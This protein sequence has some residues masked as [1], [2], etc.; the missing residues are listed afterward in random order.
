MRNDP[1]PRSPGGD[2]AAPR[3]ALC[4]IAARNYLPSVQL[5]VESFRRH[6]A[7]VAVHAL[8]VDADRH[9]ET[10]DLPFE[11]LV[12]EDLP[13]SGDEFGRM[14]T[15][16]DITELSTALKPTLMRALLDTFDVVMYLDPDIEVFAPLDG[17]FDSARV[18]GIA[19][20]PH[21]TR[22]LPRDGRD[23]ADEAFLISGQFN[24]GFI[25]LSSDAGEFVDYWEERTRHLAIVDPAKGYFTDQRWV[26]AVPSL[27]SHEVVRDDGC[28]VAYWNLHERALDVDADDRW[29]VNGEPLRFFHF[30]GHDDRQPFRLSRHLQ[31][32][33]RVRVDQHAPLR[34]LLAERAQRIAATRGDAI[35]APY[36]LGRMRCGVRID[37]IAR[38]SFWEAAHQAHRAGGPHPPHAFDAT[39]GKAF[40]AWMTEPVSP[41]AP[42]S[43]YLYEHWRRRPDLQ[44]AY[45]DPL[46]STGAAL[47]H[48]ASVDPGFLA[49]TPEELHPNRP[50]EVD[51][52]VNLVGYL[53]GEFG[54]GTASRLMARL[55]RGAGLPLA[56]TTIFTEHH[57][58]M[59]QPVTTIEGAPFE[60]SLLMLNADALL[61][62]WHGP[63]LAVHHQR[64]RVG[65]WYWEVGVL[66]E[67][68]RP[69]FGLL[70][71]VWCASEYVRSALEPWADRPV[72]KHPLALRPAVPT[73]LSRSDVGLPQDRFVFGFSFDYSSVTRRKNP[74]GLIDGYRR[75]F[76]PDDG[77]TLAIKVIHAE[78]WTAEAAEVREVARGRDDIL[79]IDRF[80]DPL[81]M[82]AFF[83]LLDCYVSL[84][85]AEGLGLTIASA[86]A[87]GVPAIATGW[88]GNLEFM[89]EANSLL[90]PF[91]LTEVGDGAAPYPPDACWAE[92]DLDAAASMMRMLFDDRAA[93]RDLG[94]RGA[95]DL[96]G[97]QIH[98][99]GADWLVDRYE[100]LTGT[101]I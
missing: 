45:P 70:D 51:P 96:A 46:G 48:W 92:P 26:D 80:F 59:A 99:S 55:V 66:P 23:V 9:Y 11:V 13:L 36:A 95:R 101:R 29:L 86:M 85:R 3:F 76:G 15:Y 30:S 21:V 34:R 19:L 56:T 77:A 47:S 75:A 44:A 61:H 58:H 87:A 5:L 57:R 83:Q 71:E 27:F 39:G 14:A 64:R 42:V 68:M 91:Q 100:R 37:P 40:A 98:R 16:Y 72:L 18:H 22:P 63:E 43:R 60:L 49:S 35:D 53:A 52:G 93:A 81:E 62:L 8:V 38:R 73:A 97:L 2:G 10:R 31:G 1:E 54:V 20:T 32:R 89:S 74:M 50:S 4:T 17:L 88:S 84:H 12:P 79:F 94:M 41:R 7:D 6:H 90:V 82:R 65:V 33:A 24:L 67:P 78:Q 69:A 28:N 25:A